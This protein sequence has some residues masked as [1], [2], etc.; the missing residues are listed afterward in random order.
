LRDVAIKLGVPK[1]N[2]LLTGNV[3]NTYQEAI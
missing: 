3:E 2:I 1:E